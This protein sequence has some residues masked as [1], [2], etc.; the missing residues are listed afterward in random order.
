MR[1]LLLIL[2]STICCN[3]FAQQ[4]DSSDYYRY[5]YHIEEAKYQISHHNTTDAV[6][7]LLLV[8]NTDFKNSEDSLNQQALNLLQHIYYSCNNTS[9]KIEM[10]G[11]PSGVKFTNDGKYIGAVNFIGG[12]LSQLYIFDS[13]TGQRV[14]KEMPEEINPKSFCFSPQSDRVAICS[15]NHI[16]EWDILTNKV[17][18]M[19]T[20][21]DNKVVQCEYSP[22]GTM[23]YVLLNDNKLKCIY[24]KEN[25]I[26]DYD[27]ENNTTHRFQLSK[28]GK[29]ILIHG[30]ENAQV[31]D[32][33]R[34]A[35]LFESR[36]KKY[37]AALSPG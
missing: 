23:L 12:E 25:K 29:R 17:S 15:D 16:E 34:N 19:T 30:N 31:W 10:T 13:S 7:H 21:T 37:H 14:N 28:N 5:K 27:F 35:K 26:T 24:L 32:L 3:L 6:K 20:L 9:M 1:Q 18:A 11:Y 4:K 22:C 8:L 36:G 2:A 33:E